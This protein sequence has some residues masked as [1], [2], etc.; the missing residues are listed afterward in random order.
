MKEIIASPN[1]PAAIGPY[2][3]GVRSGSFVFV[4]GQLPIDPAA[5]DIVKGDVASQTEQSLRNLAAVLEQAGGSLAEVVKTT[6]FLANIADFAAMNQV[7]QRYFPSECPARSAFQVAALP[8]GALVEIE[9]I[10]AV[11]AKGAVP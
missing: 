1:A 4:S 3:Q 6:V 8:K 2:S 11:P 9:A 10:A 7:Y 5:G